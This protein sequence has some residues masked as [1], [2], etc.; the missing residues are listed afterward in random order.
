MAVSAQLQ[1]WDSELEQWVPYNPA[2]HQEQ[3]VELIADAVGEAMPDSPETGLA[4]DVVLQQ[5][6]D[7]LPPVARR[8]RPSRTRPRRC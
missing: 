2:E 7:R 1:V 6:R 5:V 3:L 8:P 4:K